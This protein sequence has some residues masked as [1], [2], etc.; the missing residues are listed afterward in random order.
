ME[1]EE[2]PYHPI[3]VN[4]MGG[5]G[6]Q[7]FQYAAARAVAHH[8]PG[9][10]Y[11]EQET[12]NSHNHKQYDYARI[13]MKHAVVVG[14]APSCPHAFHQG[15]SFAPWQPENIH[16]P[17]KLNGYFQY[18]PPIQPILSDLVL[19]Y[20]DALGPFCRDV[21]H[22]DTSLFIHVRR[23]DYLKLPHYHY[24]QTKTYYENAFKKW[25][26]Q[27]KGGDDDFHVFLMSDDPEWCRDQPWS[28]PYTLYE[29]DDEVQT[30][31]LMSQCR[32]GA[33]ISNSSFSYWGAMLSG[34][35]HVFY[36]ER[37]IAET[38]HDLFPS[39]WCCVKG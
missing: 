22:P 25:R 31:A 37:W 8:H 39:H 20:K 23:G 14:T 15:S 21:V 17:V 3:V 9:Q 24:I 10:I 12:E 36:P 11:V 38:V 26:E 34:S 2:R 29:N 18:L 19:E 16:P 1:T 28:F 27:Y 32:A 4:R 30:L 7:L 35:A 5:L 6:N 33:I 13:F